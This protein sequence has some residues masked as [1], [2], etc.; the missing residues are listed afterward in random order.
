MLLAG[1]TKCFFI[2]KVLLAKPQLIVW[3]PFS[4]KISFNYKKPLLINVNVAVSRRW[5][6]RSLTDKTNW[7]CFFYEKIYTGRM[8]LLNGLEML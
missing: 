8:K 5:V 6:V 4:Y 1:F 2:N 3:I 7:S